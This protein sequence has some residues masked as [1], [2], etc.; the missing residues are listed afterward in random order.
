[1]ER[2]AI[3]REITRTGEAMIERERVQFLIPVWLGAKTELAL[4]RLHDLK[5]KVCEVEKGSLEKGTL[6][7]GLA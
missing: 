5:L 4:R 3:S 6:V 2:K 1:M 7:V